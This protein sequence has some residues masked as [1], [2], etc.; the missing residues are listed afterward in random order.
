VQFLLLLQIFQQLLLLLDKELE[1]LLRVDNICKTPD[2]FHPEQTPKHLVLLLLILF[3]FL[4]SIIVLIVILLLIGHLPKWDYL[5][6]LLSPGV[7]AVF[8]YVKVKVL[9]AESPPEDVNRA[10][11]HLL[12]CEDSRI[13]VHKLLSRE[14]VL[15]D[16]AVIGLVRKIPHVIPDVDGLVDAGGMRVVEVV[17]HWNHRCRRQ[18]PTKAS[19]AHLGKY[20]HEETAIEELVVEVLGVEEE[21]RL[22]VL[23]LFL[24][25][26]AV[27]VG[28]LHQGEIVCG[29]DLFEGPVAKEFD[30]IGKEVQVR[31][32]KGFLS[33]LILIHHSKS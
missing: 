30:V 31:E 8:S 6:Y 24:D 2:L 28:L 21:D 18:T 32:P 14:V 11:L 25:I 27:D 4:L 29:M 19:R 15:R 5:M 7:K 16:R 26:S 23:P 3:F 22:H 1:S 33:L 17:C 20:T 9:T 12:L 13:I 10:L